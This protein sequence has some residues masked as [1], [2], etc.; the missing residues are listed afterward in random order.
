MGIKTF[1]AD[2]V[3]KLILEFPSTHQRALVTLSGGSLEITNDK[4]RHRGGPLHLCYVDG[5]GEHRCPWHDRPAGRRQAFALVSAIYIRSRG[6]ITL[7]ADN[8]DGRE[9]PVRVVE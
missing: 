9:W 6:Q 1:R 7:V 4:C 5:T 8:V 3:P 2:G